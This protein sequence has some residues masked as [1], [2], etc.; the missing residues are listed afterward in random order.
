[1]EP[2]ILKKKDEIEQTSIKIDKLYE[3]IK[4]LNEKI[5]CL[6]EVQKC[7]ECGRLLD[8]DDLHQLSICISCNLGICKCCRML[9][10]WKD[11]FN[12]QDLG[13]C[14]NCSK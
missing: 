7:A 5:E 11:S 1:M 13:T 4:K 10:G 14:N 9:Y 6:Q 12:W 3:K 8:K 2:I